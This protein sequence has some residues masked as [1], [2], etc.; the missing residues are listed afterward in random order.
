VEGD[1]GQSRAAVGSAS[2]PRNGQS[3]LVYPSTVSRVKLDRRHARWLSAYE[4]HAVDAGD[5]ANL[6]VPAILPIP[7]TSGA[8]RR[9]HLAVLSKVLTEA[10][11]VT[12]GRTGR[13]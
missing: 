2:I 13:V 9:V 7:V 12:Y 5:V 6:T 4:I 10:E 3:R 1:D 11:L 8:G